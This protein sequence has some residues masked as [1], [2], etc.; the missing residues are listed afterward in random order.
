MWDYAVTAVRHPATEVPG[1]VT[2]WDDHYWLVCDQI[3]HRG[4][5]FL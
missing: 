5:I 2:L 1:D 3:E 4:R